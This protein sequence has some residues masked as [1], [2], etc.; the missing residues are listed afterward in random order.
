MYHIRGRADN[1]T[2]R[3]L[4]RRTLEAGD[5]EIRTFLTDYRDIPEGLVRRV[6]SCVD[7]RDINAQFVSRRATSLL[8]YGNTRYDLSE[9]GTLAP[10]LSMLCTGRTSLSAYRNHRQRAG[11]TRF[12]KEKRPSTLRH[13]PMHFI[14][15]VLSRLR[16]RQQ[17]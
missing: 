14:V 17:C 7:K 3:N 8:C 16:S 13:M 5:L 1:E 10:L 6:D 15:S 2:L 4:P 11:G 9:F 12:T